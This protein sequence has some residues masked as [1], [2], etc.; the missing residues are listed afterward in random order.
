MV[1]PPRKRAG[2]HGTAARGNPTA[3]RQT[4]LAARGNA[5]AARQRGATMTRALL[6]WYDEHARRLPWRTMADPYSTWVSEIMLQQTQVATV[7][8]YFER[9]LKLFPTVH[10]LAEAT[11]DAV[12]SAWQGLG[13]YSRARALHRS[14]QLIVTSHGGRLPS[15]PKVLRQLPGI[16][17][18]TA[19]AIASIA[20]D[21][22]EPAVDGNVMRVLSRIEALRGDPR[23]NPTLARIYEL[24][25]EWV[26][27]RSPARI[28][29]AIMEL[30]ALVCTPLQPRCSQCPIASH[31][32]A[33]ALGLADQLP[34]LPRRAP[35]TVRRVVVLV[36]QHA[37]RL[38]LVRQP[39][40]ARHWANLST[41]P[42]VELTQRETPLAAAK[43]F[44]AELDPAARLC[45]ETPVLCLSYPITR[46]RFE[47]TVY[48]ATAIRENRIKRFG[49]EYATMQ[50]VTERA[51]PAPHRRLCEK[52]GR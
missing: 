26:K 24:A 6:R 13:Y 22:S 14:A 46:F 25:A 28:N 11:Q 32:R 38:L 5:A 23:V 31:C 35:P 16:G 37:K 36:A 21:Q 39:T 17:R 44:L 29:Q 49:G 15:D 7:I 12:L 30:G 33:L 9:W 2:A 19:G 45:D 1:G 40:T 18:Y 47:A 10:A 27:R 50:E 48:R 41:L 42:Y 43:R 8:P 20:F 3:V 4:T 51:L 52:L 34:E